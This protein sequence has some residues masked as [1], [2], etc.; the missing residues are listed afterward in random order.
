VTFDRHKH[1]RRSIRLPGYDYSEPG[2]YFVTLCTYSR[3]CLLGDVH[4]GAVRLSDCGLVAR[5]EWL[6]TARLPAEIQLDAFVVMPNHLHG[7]VIIKGYG[8][9][10]GAMAANV[11]AQSLAPLQQPPLYRPRRSLGSFVAGFK[12]AVTKRVNALRGWR[13]AGRNIAP[14]NSM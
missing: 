11:G 8:E 7:I 1:H 6:R 5:E 4:A 3:E 13:G 14:I 10:V 2:T 12:M 9:R